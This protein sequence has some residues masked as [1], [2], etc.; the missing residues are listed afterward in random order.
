M[1][2]S[3]SLPL[4]GFPTYQVDILLATGEKVEGT[5][6]IAFLGMWLIFLGLHLP[7][8]TQ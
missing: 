7:D 4:E 2:W 6:W 3:K 1:S 5:A 8:W